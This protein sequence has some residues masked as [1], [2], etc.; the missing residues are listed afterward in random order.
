LTGGAGADYLDGGAGTDTAVYSGNIASYSW[1]KDASGYWIVSDLRGGSPDYIDYLIN[2]ETLRFADIFVALSSLWQVG[3]AGREILRGTDGADAI[4]G[5]GGSDDLY[6]GGG[7]DTLTGGG[8]SDYINGGSG[9]DVAVYSGGSASYSW[10]MNANGTW[11]V[12]DLL[13]GS[14]EIDYLVDMELLQFTDGL[15]DLASLRQVGTAGPEILR[16]TDGADTINGAGGSDDLYGG[17]G[18]DTLTGGA[19]SDYINGGSG[20]DV[21][22][23]SGGSASYSW[24]MNAN[25]T[26]NVQDLLSG[27]PEIDY[28]VDMEL[29]QFTDRSVAL[30]SLSQAGTNGA[31]AIFGVAE[32]P[33]F[34]QPLANTGFNPLDWHL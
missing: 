26:W 11:N 24:T 14:P 34:A 30:P 3:T 2:M 29:L 17:G 20:I 25:G 4:D 23:Y 10:T 28:L 5:A 32:Q 13:S 16:G 21:A 8:G 19:G 33:L 15:V 1:I 18:N 7:N 12:Q 9:I 22:V 31:D 27:S 6:G